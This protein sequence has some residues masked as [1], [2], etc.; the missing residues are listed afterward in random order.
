MHPKPATIASDLSG[1]ID[2]IFLRI[3]TYADPNSFEIRMLERE[4]QQLLKVDAFAGWLLKSRI[5]CLCGELDN[6]RKFNQNAQS[7]GAAVDS[8]VDLMTS[9]E[10]LGR[11]SES[12]SIFKEVGAP[13]RGVF[14]KI[15]HYGF[16]SGAFEDL[17]KHLIEAK[18]M[19]LNLSSLPLDKFDIVFKILRNDQVTQEEVNTI[20]DASGEIL[21]NRR[22]FFTDRRPTYFIESPTSSDELGCV[23]FHFGVPFAPEEAAEMNFE[24]AD[25]IARSSI[26]IPNAFSVSFV[27]RNV[28][29]TRAAA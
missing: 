11:F 18:K 6:L 14:T 3:D 7:L 2:Q 1:K 13:E 25:K 8:K 22:C 4:A 10:V 16:A 26:R 21:I 28:N 29:N 12:S 20:M 19:G 23:H 9:L 24:L 5:S 15:A 17:Q 27:A